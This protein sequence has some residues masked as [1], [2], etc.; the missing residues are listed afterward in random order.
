MNSHKQIF[1]NGHYFVHGL[2]FKVLD[3]LFMV[4]NNFMAIPEEDSS[5]VMDA[6]LRNCLSL[7]I[8]FLIISICIFLF[9][10]II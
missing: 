2:I 4:N 5:I 9:E 7:H 3:K 6:F 1:E 10:K 8:V